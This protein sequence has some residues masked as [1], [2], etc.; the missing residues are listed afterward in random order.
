[1]NRS[2]KLY[3]GIVAGLAAV[4]LWNAGWSYSSIDPVAHWNAVAAI[5]VLCFVSEASYLKLR[6]GRTQTQSSVAF[7]PYIGSFLLF[8][9]G[10]AAAVAAGSM[11]GVEVAVRRK[12]PIRILFNV[13]QMILCIGVASLVFQAFGGS[14]TVAAEVFTVDALASAGGI[15][16]YFLIN[17][18]AVSVAVTLAYGTP[19]RDAW[20]RI[21]GASL[22][23]DL[24]SSP[25]GVLLAFLY[26]KQELVGILVLILPIY[27]VR[28][29]YYVNLQLEQ[30]N[31][32]LLEL[33][34]KAIEARDPYTSGHSLRV[35]RIAELIAK[36]V[37][38][39]HRAVEQ[40]ATAAL[41]H[42]VGKI[43][44]DFA[45]LLRKESRLDSTEKALMQ[46]HPTRSAELVA[47]ISGFRGLIEEAVRYHHENYDGS[48]YPRG[49]AGRA[50]PIGARIIMIAD[51]VDAMT[52]DRPY[53]R[54][55]SYDRVI[56]E[57]KRYAGRQF[58]PELVERVTNSSAI[59]SLVA[60]RLVSQ[61]NPA[62]G[63]ELAVRDGTRVSARI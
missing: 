51:T 57:L 10:W 5:S 27:F 21:A 19:L 25:L 48:G 12:P 9:S 23:Y 22:I 39:G 42:D 16:T 7:I 29:I 34:V 59:R 17:S 49:L 37:G 33:M 61:R 15:V 46:T 60:S 54:A 11:L 62:D 32:D 55:L 31:R 6:V 52:T 20:V 56:E 45:P 44:E 53:R 50:I 4:F 1:M 41:L 35:S 24:F 13:S 63:Y 47:T 2:F 43:Y 14:F 36:D 28:H 30:V 8:D 38:L 18:A 26:A 40:I 3:T 58:D